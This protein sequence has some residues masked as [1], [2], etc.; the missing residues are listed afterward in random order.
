[1]FFFFL[2][3]D[4]VVKGVGNL[5]HF[6]DVEVG[7][8]PFHENCVV[9]AGG[10]SRWGAV[11]DGQTE[12]VEDKVDHVE[13]E[14]SQGVEESSEESDLLSEESAKERSDELS[15]DDGSEDSDEERDELGDLAQ[16]E[17]QGVSGSSIGGGRGLVGCGLIGG[18]SILLLVGGSSIGCSRGLICG[19]SSVFSSG[20][21]VGVSGGGVARVVGSGGVGVA[22]SISQDGSEEG[23]GDDDFV[24]V[25]DSNSNSRDVGVLLSR[26]SG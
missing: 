10:G 8:R 1:L 23:N 22:A 26:R 4:G 9:A 7:E 25:E 12:S 19:G 3:R 15:D 11:C 2:C 24:H 20:T 14:L 13:L 6:Q 17:V 21:G 16:V 18:G 5:N